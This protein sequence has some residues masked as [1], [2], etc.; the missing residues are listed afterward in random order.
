GEL[1]ER[2]SPLVP[3]QDVQCL[4]EVVRTVAVLHGPR[5]APPLSGLCEGLRP[6]ALGILRRL[7]RSSRSDL[8]AR[9]ASA[10]G[11][12]GAAPRPRAGAR[13]GVGGGAGVRPRPPRVRACRGDT[14]A[15]GWRCRKTAARRRVRATRPAQVRPR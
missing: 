8:H 4:E 9:L 10:F 7:E 12:R 3:P 14:L 6:S 2:R 1:V 5:A 13:G 15:P 11:P